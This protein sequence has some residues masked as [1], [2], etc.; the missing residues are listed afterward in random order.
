MPEKTDRSS[1]SS[2]AACLKY[3]VVEEAVKGE[4]V[5]FVFE[6]FPVAGKNCR[7]SL[8]C[9]CDGHNGSG[10]AK[11]V[12]KYFV[13][14]LKKRFPK[15]AV[16]TN[17]H[18]AEGQRYASMIIEALVAAFEDIDVQWRQKKQMSGTTI[19]VAVVVGW[20]LTV[21]N[22]GDSLAFLNS[23]GG[24]RQLTANHRLQ[25]NSCEVDRLRSAGVQ[26]ATVSFDAAG[27]AKDGEAGFGPLRAWPAGLAVSRT[28]GDIDAG[29][30]VICRPHIKQVVIPR[31]GARLVLA[32]D[33]LWD[34]LRPRKVKSLVKCREL[35]DATRILLTAASRVALGTLSDD[36]T[37]LVVDIISS[38][39]F[40]SGKSWHPG[41][42]KNP[43]LQRCFCS[44]KVM[45]DAK[46]QF[47]ADVDTLH[48]H[49]QIP[50]W[51]KVTKG[52]RNPVDLTVHHGKSFEKNRLGLNSNSRN[53]PKQRRPVTVKRSATDTTALSSGLQVP[54]SVN[55]TLETH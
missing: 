44:P 37:V 46:V 12:E 42:C 1:D 26:V 10:A 2:D 45:D 28:I 6:K 9:V 41:S 39:W 50:P 23:V 36:I 53:P 7:A 47:I 40:H 31:T 4:D 54:I 18:S 21:A 25:T 51:Q 29:P 49:A 38:Q 34:L 32:T 55:P 15:D 52:T 35:N 19:T 24:F 43:F 3:A 17:W 5:Y 30:E 48:T 8:Y 22:V 20:L 13:E 11:F 16:P 27:P 33:G 14:E